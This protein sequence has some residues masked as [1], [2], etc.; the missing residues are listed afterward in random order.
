[1]K[2]INWLTIQSDIKE[3]RSQLQAIEQLLAKGEEV[4]EEA[5]RVMMQHAYFHLNYAWNA[6][7]VTTERYAE[8]TDRDFK[9]WGSYP[10]TIDKF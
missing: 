8:C 4:E 2:K 9:R 3:A 5:L 10:K 1:M 6:R 7:H